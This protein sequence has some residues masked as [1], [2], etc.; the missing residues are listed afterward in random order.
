MSSHLPY[1][2]YHHAS[3]WNQLLPQRKIQRISRLQLSYRYV[4][5]GAG[6]TGLAA[7]R[8]L[9]ELNPSEQILLL[10]AGEIGEGSSGRNS[11]FLISL[12]HHANGSDE[13][14]RRQMRLYDAGKNALKQLVDQYDIQ[15]DWND[16]GKYHSA[17]TKLGASTL[18][19]NMHQLENWG[20]TV[21]QLS[22]DESF[23][24]FGTDYYR[25]SFHTT[26]NVF[27]Q[28]AALIRGLAD[29]LPDNVILQEHEP[30]LKLDTNPSETTIQLANTTIRAETVILAN[31]SFAKALGILSDRVA[32]IY[33]YAGLTP[34]L[35]D[36]ALDQHGIEPEWGIIPANRL[37]TTLRKT[38]NGR[39]LIRSAYSYEKQM[40]ESAMRNILTSC[41]KRR[42]P[43]LRHHDFEHIWSGVT[44]LTRNGAPFFGPITNNVFA[45]VGC[46]G[47][48][49][50][51]GTIYGAL[52]AEASMGGQSSLLTDAL[53]LSQPNWLP[54][55]PLRRMAIT[56]AIR[57]HL[58]KAGR[59]F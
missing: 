13:I 19:A 12:P 15:C 14:A 4:V 55:E 23:A 43:N 57:L 32:T 39:F 1:P 22:R 51:K 35:D 48:G 37:G 56:A 52:L 18:E 25:Y 47:V 49:I 10:E 11:G 2:T 27:V 9:A 50:L 17:A 58:H 5:I 53:S 31:N 46:N 38:S 21:H 3:G 40:S 36:K 8:R 59:E 41:Y 24:R 30:V 33:T 26:H 34:E 29:S 45:S 42:Y 44:A 28:P 16:I 20:I 54:P 6:Y 7:A